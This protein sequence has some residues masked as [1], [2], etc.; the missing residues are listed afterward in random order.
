MQAIESNSRLIRTIL[1]RMPSLIVAVLFACTSVV[2]IGHAQ[3]IN[4]L[5]TI[6]ENS[7]IVL[8]PPDVRYYLI[9]A[10]GVREHHAEWSQIAEAHMTLA[11]D[12]YLATIGAAIKNADAAN[13]GETEVGFGRL[14]RVVGLTIIDQDAKSG[15]SMGPGVEQ[16][17]Q[18]HNADY[19]LFVHFRNYQAS[20][21]RV[22]FAI[23]AAAAE[24][25]MRTGSEQGF[26]SLVD[27][28]TGDVVWFN[29]IDDVV[30][31]IRQES[32]SRDAVNQLFVV[33]QTPWTGQ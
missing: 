27:L 24:L 12:A 20:G 30:G 33:A 16:I 1:L 15:G 22:A 25:N 13:L 10:G 11:M 32:G 3:Q 17:A 29:S 19:A 28:R 5:E 31:E 6:A 4:Q 8:M 26:A 7:S 14:H 9:T 2:S 18:R 21:G 23:L